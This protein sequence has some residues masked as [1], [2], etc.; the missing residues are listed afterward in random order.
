MIGAEAQSSATSRPPEQ[1]K[2]QTLAH[3]TILVDFVISTIDAEP[4]YPQITPVIH[5]SAFFDFNRLI[6]ESDDKI[7]KE[8]NKLVKS[9]IRK[10]I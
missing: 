9:N 10:K 4:K 1:I 2:W 7:R 8:Y 5:P 3:L 6:F